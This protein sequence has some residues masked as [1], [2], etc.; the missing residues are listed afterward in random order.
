VTAAERQTLDARR[1]HARQDA[2]V[3]QLSGK[4]SSTAKDFALKGLRLPARCHE[5][6]CLSALAL[7]FVKTRLKALKRRR[8][9]TEGYVNRSAFSSYLE[10]VEDAIFVD[11]AVSLYL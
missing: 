9:S 11:D 5:R 4:P 7:I 2:S 1:H 10:N 8:A 6:I 3:V